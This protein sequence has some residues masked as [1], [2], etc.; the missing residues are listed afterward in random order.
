MNLLLN[1]NNLSGTIRDGFG[2]FRSL[3]FVDFSA[4]QLTGTIP[5]TLFN[6]RDL[7]FLYLSN[8]K[9]E[10]ALPE[11]WG[12][13]VL[14]RDFFVDNNNLSGS[15]PEIPQGAFTRL[16]ELL[17]N[18]NMFTGEMP[19]SICQLRSSAIL[20]DLWADCGGTPPEVQ[21]ALPSCC[22]FCFE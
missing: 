20:E 7:R 21:C 12:N 14:L 3:D 13:A 1:D 17:L 11:N 6:I 2:S 19:G 5:T 8:N 15:V 4:N 22:T 10:G 16:T 9:L 18:G